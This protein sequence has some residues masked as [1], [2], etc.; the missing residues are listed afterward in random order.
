MVFPSFCEDT[1]EILVLTAEILKNII[2]M[3]KNK[4]TSQPF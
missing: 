2:F 3:M 4:I 1:E